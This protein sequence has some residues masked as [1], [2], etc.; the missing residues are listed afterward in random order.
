MMT[1]LGGGFLAAHTSAR[2]SGTTPGGGG[3]HDNINKIILIVAI[4]ICLHLLCLPLYLYYVHFKDDKEKE[5][6]LTSEYFL[7]SAEHKRLTQEVSDSILNWTHRNAIESANKI[8]IKNITTNPQQVQ[9]AQRDSAHYATQ[10]TEFVRNNALDYICERYYY[11][12]QHQ[13]E[14]M[15][16]GVSI[17]SV[18]KD[19]R[20]QKSLKKYNQAIQ[21]L[22]AQ[23]RYNRL[24]KT[25]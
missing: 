14:H 16:I 15:V 21:N 12:P 22:E 24:H 19:K 4:I 25:K 18:Y 3:D 7:T 10:I 23:R 5:D 13:Q 20:L 11:C 6:F 2:N 9:Q 17:P 1:P 8:D